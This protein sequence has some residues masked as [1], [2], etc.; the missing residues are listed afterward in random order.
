MSDRILV[1]YDESPQSRAALE[2]A[3]STYPEAEVT[4]LHV[5]DPREW[6]YPDELGGGYYADEAF[7][8]AQETAEDLLADAEALARDRGREVSTAGATGRPANTIVEYA[9]EH[10]VDH[11]VMGSHGRT[12]FSRILLGSVAESVVR[13][14]PVSVTIIRGAEADETA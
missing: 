9:E 5:T 4:V 10:D 13:R 1:A 2:H 11:I 8:R 6:I 12:G 7:E 14:S 3:L